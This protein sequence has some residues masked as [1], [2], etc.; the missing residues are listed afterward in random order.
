MV[1]GWA[2]NTTFNQL[3]LAQVSGALAELGQVRRHV[4]IH[5]SSAQDIGIYS[6]PSFWSATV[7]ASYVLNAS[8]PLWCD[9]A[10]GLHHHTT[11]GRYSNDDGE[12]S[13]DDWEPFGGWTQPYM[14][15]CAWHVLHHHLMRRQQYSQGG[16]ACGIPD[17]DFNWYAALHRTAADRV[18]ARHAKLTFTPSFACELC[19]AGAAGA[20]TNGPPA[21]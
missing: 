20:W 16:N 4:G 21:A 15:A 11:G 8:L 9:V 17:T 12:M 3:L 10:S 14:K 19:M 13:Y 18:Q 1:A 7:G 2:A 6:S 5:S